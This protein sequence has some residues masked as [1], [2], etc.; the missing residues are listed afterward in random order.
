[1][2][3]QWKSPSFLR[4]NQRFLCSFSIANCKRLPEGREIWK[5]AWRVCLERFGSSGIS[6]KNAT[7]DA[8]LPRWYQ[9]I[10][11]RE[12]LPKTVASTLGYRGFLDIL[13]PSLGWYWWIWIH[14]VMVC[15]HD[16]TGYGWPQS[17]Q[18]NAT[19]PSSAERLTPSFWNPHSTQTIWGRQ[20][21][22]QAPSF[23]HKP[24]FPVSRTAPVS[25]KGRT[26]PAELPDSSAYRS[27]PWSVSRGIPRSELSLEWSRETN[28]GVV[29][30]KLLGLYDIV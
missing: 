8:Q 25:S 12:N 21:G 13:P 20:D 1:M 23:H 18:S 4:L 22:P 24:C 5:N 19:T 6:V 30:C 16:C 29:G 7:N 26:A 10:D 14:T 11:F 9:W 27:L 17:L 28:D 2:E 15:P 3:N